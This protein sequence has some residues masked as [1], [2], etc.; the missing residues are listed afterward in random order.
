MIEFLFIVFIP[1]DEADQVLKT[2]GNKGLLEELINGGRFEE[3]RQGNAERECFEEV[4]NY[5][6]AFEVFDKQPEAVSFCTLR[7]I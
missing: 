4:C 6:E 2:A 1:K 7:F 3:I 5:E